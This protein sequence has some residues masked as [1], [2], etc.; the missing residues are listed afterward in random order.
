MK[1]LKPPAKRRP[2]PPD[3]PALISVGQGQI[4][5]YFDDEL[6]ELD[7]PAEGRRLL[8]VLNVSGF[9]VFTASKLNRVVSGLGPTHFEGTLAGR[10]L[11]RIKLD[12]GPVVY[13]T[14]S[15]FPASVSGFGE[16]V[17][18][19][20]YC[21]ELNVVFGSASWTSEQ[22]FRGTLRHQLRFHAKVGRRG[23][24]GG[25]KGFFA[26][27]TYSHVDYLDI[28]SA[29]PSAMI[30]EPVPLR[31]VYDPSDSI[32]SPVGLALADVTVPDSLDSFPPLY[33]VTRFGMLWQTGELRGWFPLRELRMAREVGCQVRPWIVYQ[34]RDYLS[35]FD[36][37][38]DRM[39][40]LR[41]LP[42]SAGRMGKVIANALWGTFANGAETTVVRFLDDP[43]CRVDPDSVSIR[44]PP[45]P[46]A[47]FVACEISSRV[48]ERV[49]RELGPSKPIYVDTDGGVIRRSRP[50]PDRMGD[51]IGDWSVRDRFERFEL[52]GVGA[53]IGHRYD[54]RRSVVLSGHEGIASSVDVRRAGADGWAIADSS[55]SGFKGVRL[56]PREPWIFDR[57]GQP[58]PIEPNRWSLDQL[59]GDWS[60]IHPELAG[61]PDFEPVRISSLLAEPELSPIPFT[62][63]SYV[64]GSDLIDPF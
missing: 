14:R 59:P 8:R 17:D 45:P 53:Y 62:S 7:D 41:A 55:R 34:G 42:G 38:H 63:S 52:V 30:E 4:R 43:G 37:W 22:I 12:D 1:R 46:E 29:Y 40:E 35:P 51:A 10:R 6:I 3:R 13:G 31:L 54:G 50:L 20:N 47:A 11:I 61:L 2:N 9:R 36:H 25:R 21:R 58:V 49:F 57:D 32:E 27:G 15:I 44:R 64:D 48:R 33:E 39:V 60:V 18:L 5:A 26:P 23:A 19:W 16:L 56:A 24:R 28:R